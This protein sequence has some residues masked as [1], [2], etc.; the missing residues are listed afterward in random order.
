VDR[1]RSELDPH[2]QTRRA[3]LAKVGAGVGACTLAAAV[4]PLSAN[5]SQAGIDEGNAKYATVRSWYPWL[6]PCT[7]VD[8][9]APAGPYYASF[10]QTTWRYE[11]QMAVDRDTH[12]LGII[13]HEAG[14]IMAYYVS[15]S[16]GTTWNS[17][18]HRLYYEFCVYFGAD[19]SIADR[20]DMGEIWAEHFAR[21]HVPGYNPSYPQLVGVVP[22]DPVTGPQKMKDFC[23]SI[24]LP[25]E[26]GL[27]YISGDQA[28][29]T[30]SNGNAF[31]Q[32][33]ISG[34]A[35]AGGP[36]LGFAQRIGLAG[37][38]PTLPYCTFWAVNNT[39]GYLMVRGDPVHSGTAWF[40]YGAI[41]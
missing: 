16:R 26:D 34:L 17:G 38:E 1:S 41:Q 29:T 20:P 28:V 31:V 32:K 5:A 6:P 39:T 2:G 23:V 27:Q 25:S 18:T 24:A 22:F 15:N 9:G 36:I 12:G 37:S 10:N 8:T 4:R 13:E 21:A 14:H 11:I 7:M 19:P 3:F 30:D 35:S 40:R 33:P